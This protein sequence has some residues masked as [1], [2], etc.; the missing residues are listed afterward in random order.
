MARF[1]MLCDYFIR[2]VIIKNVLWL[3]E[4]D[5]ILT[6]YMH[7]TLILNIGLDTTSYYTHIRMF[8]RYKMIL[9]I[10]FLAFFS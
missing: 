3:R 7:H 8:D 6:A 4:S 2:R 1:I 10:D 5:P 9:E